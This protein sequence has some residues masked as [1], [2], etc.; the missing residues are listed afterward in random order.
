MEEKIYILMNECMPGLIK[1]GRTTTN[2]EQRM[3]ELY[4]TGVPYPFHCFY[5]AIVD[6]GDFVEKKLHDAFG[7][8]R[9]PSNREFFKISPH[10]VKAAIELVAIKEVTPSS[11]PELTSEM[12]DFVSRR[13]SFRFSIAKI[14]PGA[15]LQFVRDQQI[16]CKVI[17][18]KSIEFRGQRTSLSAAALELLNQL[19]RKATQIQGPIYWLYEGE[20][21]EERRQRIEAEA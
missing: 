19:G 16:V 21:L 15:E 9:V 12:K 20:T 13:P 4:T 3:K 2:V 8:H 11:D 14:P 1:I 6:D 10:R 17:D 18:D 7:D 5:A